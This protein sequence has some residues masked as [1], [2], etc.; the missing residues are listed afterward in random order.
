MVIIR[1]NKEIELSEEELR[2]AMY[3][4]FTSITPIEDR[5]FVDDA[6]DM[7]LSDFEENL[8]ECKKNAC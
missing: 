4:Y 5:A 6:V 2:I 7:T 3:E 8:K 1:N